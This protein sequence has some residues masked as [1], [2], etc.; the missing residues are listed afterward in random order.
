MKLRLDEDQEFI[1]KMSI[2][3]YLRHVLVI[4]NFLSRIDLNRESGKNDKEMI[5]LNSNELKNFSNSVNDDYCA[6][7]LAKDL[8]LLSNSEINSEFTTIKKKIIFE[9]FYSSQ[10]N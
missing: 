6:K 4:K 2:A 9:T 8:N 1:R 7:L 10:V 5:A 3:H